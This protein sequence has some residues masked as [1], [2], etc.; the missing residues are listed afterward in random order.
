MENRKVKQALSGDWYQGEEG[1]D[2]ERY[3]K[4]NM[5]EIL[6]THVWKWKNESS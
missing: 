4:V 2:K 5:V 3:R 6:Y 1:G